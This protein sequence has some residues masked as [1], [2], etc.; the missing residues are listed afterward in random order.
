[1][2]AKSH[3]VDNLCCLFHAV[4]PLAIAEP[5]RFDFGITGNLSQ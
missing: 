1:L 4:M 2:P 5:R 3:V